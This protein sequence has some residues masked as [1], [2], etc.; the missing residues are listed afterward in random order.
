M[1]WPQLWNGLPSAQILREKY[2]NLGLERAKLFSWDIA[3]AKMD[4]LAMR[5]L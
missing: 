2:R 5:Y 3:A 4:S 1:I